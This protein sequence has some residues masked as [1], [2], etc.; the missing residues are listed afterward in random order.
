MQEI[1]KVL[2]IEH[3]PILLYIGS[4]FFLLIFDNMVTQIV[5]LTQELTDPI[6]MK[7]L[8]QKLEAFYYVCKHESREPLYILVP[9]NLLNTD[10]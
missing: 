6:L 9:S 4:P 1:D 2:L 5:A 10:M 8:W 3:L 7:P